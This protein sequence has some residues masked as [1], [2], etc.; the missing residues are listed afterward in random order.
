MKTA[1]FTFMSKGEES[2]YEISINDQ[3]FKEQGLTSL[4]GLRFT[5]AIGTTYADTLYT[6]LYAFRLRTPKKDKY[7]YGSSW[8]M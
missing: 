1:D 3:I 6:T 4:K 2:V 8:S 5:F 7:E